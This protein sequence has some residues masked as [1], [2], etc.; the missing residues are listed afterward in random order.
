MCL[1]KQLIST[2]RESLTYVFAS[3]QLKLFLWSRG[4]GA[5]TL[6]TPSPYK[7]FSFTHLYFKMFLERFLNG[8][9]IPLQASF[10]VTPIPS[11]MSAPSKNLNYTAIESLSYKCK[12]YFTTC[13]CFTS[14]FYCLFELKSFTLS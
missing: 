1:P 5:D 12:T 10:T 13:F 6:S 9:T 11:T 3:I 4:R 7:Q 14:V 2:A 8:P